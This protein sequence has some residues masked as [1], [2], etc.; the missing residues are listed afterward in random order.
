MLLA[1][2]L[3][4]AASPAVVSKTVRCEGWDQSYLYFSPDQGHPLPAVV[5]LHGAGDRAQNMVEAWKR[6]AEKQK[7]VLLAP[8]LPRDLKF[9]DAAPRVF[10]CVVEDAKHFVGIDARRVYLFGNS[11][12][13]YLAFD[14]AMSSRSTLQRLQCMPTASPTTMSGS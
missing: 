4:A 6:F 2:T 1:P 14:G 12:G 9:E 3:L 5:L 7:I 8:E 11:M 10:R 13:G